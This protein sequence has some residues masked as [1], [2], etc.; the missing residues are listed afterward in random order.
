MANYYEEVMRLWQA[1]EFFEAIS[2]FSKYLFEELLSESEAEDFGKNLSE[3]WK[4]IEAE[5]EQA[6]SAFMRW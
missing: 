5:C 3:F 6:P 4:L 1:G 2:C